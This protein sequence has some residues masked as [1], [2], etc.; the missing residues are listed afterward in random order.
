MPIDRKN[1]VCFVIA[2]KSPD[3]SWH[4]CA[5]NEDKA[6]LR[7]L[8][9]DLSAAGEKA[10]VF[11]SKPSDELLR[12]AATGLGLA[13]HTEVRAHRLFHSSDSDESASVLS[14]KVLR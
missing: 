12:A 3:G 9:A 5:L 1:L 6:W 4:G 14:R 8:D 7:P 13:E 10:G 11:C 2:L